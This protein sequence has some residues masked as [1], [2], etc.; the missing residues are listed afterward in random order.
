MAWSGRT[1]S[2][3]GERGERGG[4]AGSTGRP[5]SQQMDEDASTSLRTRFQRDPERPGGRRLVANV[6]ESHLLAIEM[7]LDLSQKNETTGGSAH[8]CPAKLT[9]TPPCI[10]I[11]PDTS[12]M[13]ATPRTTT[14]QWGCGRTYAKFRSR[15]TKAAEFRLML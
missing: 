9:P 13:M 8:I 10:R 14:K 5:Q 4:A 7:G 15:P 6:I 2:T 3:D 1:W 11:R 12:P